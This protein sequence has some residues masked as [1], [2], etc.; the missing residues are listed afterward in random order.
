MVDN[1][2]PCNGWCDYFMSISIHTNTFW[3]EKRDSVSNPI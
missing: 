1:C 2:F 3:T